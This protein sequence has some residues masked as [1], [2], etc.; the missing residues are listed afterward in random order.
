V[1]HLLDTHVWLWWYLEPERLDAKTLRFLEDGG[2]EL[3]FSAASIWEIAIKYRLG[4]LKLSTPPEDLMPAELARDTIQI[5]PI[6]MAHA[7]RAGA[8]PPHHQDPFDRML[9]AQAQL[10]NMTLV[11]AD[12]HFSDYKVRL[13]RA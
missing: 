4:R 11:T 9:I 7:L 10:E 3:F 13:Q 5:L 1:R 6:S 12:P 8:L 2:A